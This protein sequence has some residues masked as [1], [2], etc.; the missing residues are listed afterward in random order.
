MNPNF[1]DRLLEHPAVSTWNER[2]TWFES[3][4]DVD[5]KG[6]GYI[7]GEQATGLLIDLQAVFCAGA[8]AAVVLLALAII[9]AHLR[10]VELPAGFSGGAKVALGVLPNCEGYD[11][12]RQRRNRLTHFDSKHGHAVTVETQWS[13]RKDLE[14]DAYRAVALVADALFANPWT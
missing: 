2:R 6:G 5:A 14:R 12:L 11:W 10:E 7:I 13:E 4:F 9:D 1:L 3:Q 8:W